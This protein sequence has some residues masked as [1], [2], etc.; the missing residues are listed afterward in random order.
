MGQ[1]ICFNVC[2]R[3]ALCYI[4][5]VKLVLLD[6]PLKQTLNARAPNEFSENLPLLP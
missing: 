2:E 5:A 3:V 4:V 6:S 1:C